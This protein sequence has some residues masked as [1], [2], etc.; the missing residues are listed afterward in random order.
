MKIN[1]SSEHLE[2]GEI[3]KKLA[4]YIGSMQLGGANRVMANLVDYFVDAG[5]ETVLITDIPPQKEKKE[6]S[7]SQ[8]VKRYC[9][10]EYFG[11]SLKKNFIR[12]K[13]LR[14]IIKNEKPELVLSFMGPPNYRMI[15]STLG[16]NVKKVVSVRN[17]P[18]REYGSGIFKAIARI[19]MNVADG[20][21]FQTDDATKYF[22]KGL[23]K[24]STVIFNPVN[25][26]FYESRWNCNSKNIIA[27][28][29]LE[30]QKNYPMLIQA[31]HAFTQVYPEYELVICG[32]G[33]LR[34]SVVNL[35]KE[36]GIES[37][38]VLK[39][40]IEDVQSMLQD[41]YMYILSSDYEGMPNAL[42]EAMTVGVPCISTDCPCGGPKMLLPNSEYLV[43]CG[44]VS[45][46]KTKMVLLASNMERAK[47]YSN[48]LRNRAM[49]F[50]CDL[51]LEQWIVYLNRI[52]SG[53]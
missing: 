6:Y 36:L 31:F 1:D 21:V 18:Y 2:G 29:R 43:S 22:G 14:K 9:L 4:C 53:E 49:E 10:G 35:I 27:V 46:L 32:E 48:Q 20:C 7:I 28:G 5:V 37:K 8:K 30:E 11:N 13:E 44:D 3:M 50:K 34:N 19:V 24:K 40:Q 51:V 15:V 25:D 47:K 23:Q 38:V 12:V 26:R 17:D 52:V 16:I 42:M 39:G 45:G 41:A 33:S